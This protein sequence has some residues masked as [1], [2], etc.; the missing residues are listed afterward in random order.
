MID[1]KEKVRAYFGANP[2]EPDGPE[3]T[4][5]LSAMFDGPTKLTNF[6]VWWTDG[7]YSLTAEEKAKIIN[8]SY[9]DIEEADSNQWDFE[10][11]NCLEAPRSKQP[12]TDVRELV[13]KLS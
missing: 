13:K 3:M 8:D 6:N 11:R 9:E 4:K 7:A 1:T 2:N 10:D 12:T 5:M